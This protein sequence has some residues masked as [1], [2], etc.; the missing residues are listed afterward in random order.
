M[1]NDYSEEREIL[2]VLFP[3][4]PKNVERIFK[5]AN[6]VLK[7]GGLR[8]LNNTKIKPGIK[9]FIYQTQTDKKI[10]GEAMIKEACLLSWNEISKKYSADNFFAPTEDILH[11]IGSRKDDKLLVLFLESIKKYPIPKNYNKK[12]T[13]SYH[14]IFKNESMG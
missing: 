3:I 11:Y 13:L 14:Y 1:I 12:M 5:G 6:I 2:G 4:A 7:F 8:S 10:V 9:F